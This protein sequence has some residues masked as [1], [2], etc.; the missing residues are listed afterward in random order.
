V[1]QSHDKK[2]VPRFSH[3]VTFLQAFGEQF[4]KLYH[5][6]LDYRTH[7]DAVQ[8]TALSARFDQLFAVSS[9]YQQLD[10]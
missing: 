3:H 9:G 7:P 4:W 6:L 10:E 5:D 8:A 2:L 1:R